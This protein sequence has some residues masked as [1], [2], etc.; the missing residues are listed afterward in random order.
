MKYQSIADPD[1]IVEAVQFDPH[2][3]PWP[4]GLIP[5]DPTCKPKDMT[6]GYMDTV[7]GRVHVMA[8][9]YIVD[10]VGNKRVYHREYFE[11]SFKPIIAIGDERKG[12]YYL[13]VVD[14]G[15]GKKTLVHE[16]NDIYN[17]YVHIGMM[18]MSMGIDKITVYRDS[19]KYRCY[20]KIES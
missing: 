2:N 9:D 20:E 3:H 14:R 18:M 4:S 8:T 1:V 10:V 5:H 13:I 11:K 6:W 7:T 16:G 17:V 19:E 12:N 15:D